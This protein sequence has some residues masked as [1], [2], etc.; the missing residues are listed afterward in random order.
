MP[1]KC[2][3]F[4]FFFFAGR[5]SWKLCLEVCYKSQI[6][7]SLASQRKMINW[8]KICIQILFLS[9]SDLLELLLMIF[10]MM[11]VCFS[12]DLMTMSLW[13]GRSRLT[14]C[15]PIKVS[16]PDHTWCKNVS[17]IHS[18]GRWDDNRM[19][20][21]SSCFQ[22]DCACSERSWSQSSV[23]R[24]SPSTWLVRTTRKLNPQNWPPK[25]RKFTMSSSAV[26]HRER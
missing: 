4:S 19:L 3:I 13:H 17:I 8:G 2:N 26:M 22:M 7:A 9:T 24:T 23:R 20:T 14:N 16:P 5:R 6:T 1:L 25:P 12:T 15:C 21:L 18:F 11:F 10:L